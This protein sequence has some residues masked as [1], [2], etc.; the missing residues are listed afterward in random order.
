MAVT[1]HV[2]ELVLHGFDPRDRHAIADAVH[3]ELAAL[4]T[5]SP[6]QPSGSTSTDVIDAGSFPIDGVRSPS[7]PHEIAAAVHRE[8]TR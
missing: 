1:V 5:A 3:A 7:A 2:D 6:P 8:V 4:F